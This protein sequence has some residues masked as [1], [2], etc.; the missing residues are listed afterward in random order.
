MHPPVRLVI[1]SAFFGSAAFA[2]PSSPPERAAIRDIVVDADGCGG[3][4]PAFKVTADAS[5]KVVLE[6]GHSRVSGVRRFSISP[7][8]VR[9]AFAYLEPIRPAGKAISYA[10]HTPL[11]EKDAKDRGMLAVKWEYTDG[12]QQELYFN[13]GCAKAENSFVLQRLRAVPALLKISAYVGDIPE[14]A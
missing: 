11:C 5:G 13:Y 4:C 12:T 3:A 9:R 14:R 7:A 6:G 8:E 1:A 2:H 10:P